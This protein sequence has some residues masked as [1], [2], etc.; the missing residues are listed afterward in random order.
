M[1]IRL[2]VNRTLWKEKEKK[3]A[4]VNGKKYGQVYKKTKTC[5]CKNF[6]YA[7]V[8]DP[9]QSLPHPRH[10][11]AVAELACSFPVV[12]HFFVAYKKT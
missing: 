7:F 12:I 8:V 9:R 1:A 3:Q 6:Y 5:F 11:A 4:T 2:K 10:A